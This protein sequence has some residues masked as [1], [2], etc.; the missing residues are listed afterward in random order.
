MPPAS[1]LHLVAPDPPHGCP[2]CIESL[3][4]AWCTE[5][6][7]VLLSMSSSELSEFDGEVEI[8]CCKFPTSCR[9]GSQAP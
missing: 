3:L 1:R 7:D 4:L 6:F 9:R 5:C 8:K 2:C